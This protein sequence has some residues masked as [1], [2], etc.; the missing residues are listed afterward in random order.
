[1]FLILEHEIEDGQEL[2]HAGNGGDFEGLAGGDQAVG[3][4]LDGGVEAHGGQ[5]GHVEGGAD[6]RPAAEDG[7]FAAQGARIAVERG[8][9]DEGGDLLAIEFAQFGQAR[10]Q[11]AG[12][13][14]ADAR[15]TGEDLELAA[16]IL[17]GLDQVGD[18]AVQFVEGIKGVGSL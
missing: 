16:P 2:A 4:G 6:V 13:G 1:M 14:L 7:A 18:L 8:D 5:G 10:E 11:L 17:V 15:G 3:E 9:A 12:G